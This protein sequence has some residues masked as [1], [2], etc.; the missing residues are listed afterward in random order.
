MVDCLECA[1][2]FW[3]YMKNMK[4]FVSV[5]CYSSHALKYVSSLNLI[6]S[7]YKYESC[8]MQKAFALR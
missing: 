5:S 6:I 7:L 8:G 3:A 1:K 4:V 2:K